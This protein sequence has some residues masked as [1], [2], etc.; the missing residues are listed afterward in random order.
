MAVVRVLIGVLGDI[1]PDGWLPDTLDGVVRY[2]D[3]LGRRFDLLLQVGDV[4][5]GPKPF[6]FNHDE[7]AE[8]RERVAGRL[9]LPIGFIRGNHETLSGLRQLAGDTSVAPAAVEPAGVLGWIPDGT[10]LDFDGVRIGFAGGA[11]GPEDR[12]FHPESLDLLR[13]QRPVH[14]LITHDGP[15]GLSLAMPDGTLVGEPA[16]AAF[17]EEEDGP[18][19][20]VFGHR[21][22]AMGPRLHRGPAV[23][24]TAVSGPMLTMLLP[25]H[26]PPEEGSLGVL[27][28]DA[29]TFW[30]AGRE[31]NVV[32]AVKR[33]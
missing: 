2:Q 5:R 7:L 25:A 32:S 17:I 10:V 6:S 8:A 13:A 18:A 12:G 16:I 1:E 15:L 14:V 29:R 31:D 23:G 27:D 11:L 9:P 21:H 4:S 28:C 24:G 33:A 22:H 30:V 26:R 20:S 3:R 19:L